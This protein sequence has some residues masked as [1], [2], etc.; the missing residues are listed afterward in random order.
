MEAPP[1]HAPLVW[2]PPEKLRRKVISCVLMAAFT[3]G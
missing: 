2:A 1:N 3:A